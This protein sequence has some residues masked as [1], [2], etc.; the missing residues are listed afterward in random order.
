MIFWGIIISYRKEGNNFM[1]N[2]IEG[3][4][5]ITEDSLVILQK[6]VENNRKA[7]PRRYGPVDHLKIGKGESGQGPE[8]KKGEKVVFD[9]KGA[10][11]IGK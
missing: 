10:L 4:P 6:E 3:G 7:G 1:P 9:L 2:P 11:R 5:K 8:N